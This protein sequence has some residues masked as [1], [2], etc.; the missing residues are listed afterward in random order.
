MSRSLVQLAVAVATWAVAAP[1]SAQ[2]NNPL[3]LSKSQVIDEFAR[4]AGIGADAATL[5]L[6]NT[7]AKLEKAQNY[8]AA[9][10]IVSQLAD[11]RDDAAASTAIDWVLG[12]VKDKV[13]TGPAAAALTAVTLYKSSLEGLRDWV[14]YPRWN[15][16]MYQE[17]KRAR[18]EGRTRA[19][20]GPET[21]ETAYNMATG[22]G[23]AY[24][25][26]KRG[27]YDD[28]IRAKGLTKDHIGPRVDK[29]LWAQIDAYLEARMELRFQRDYLRE[30]RDEIVQAYWREARTEL[31]TPTA[32]VG[33]TRPGA[34]ASAADEAVLARYKAAEE[35]RMQEWLAY[36]KRVGNMETAY[37][38]DWPVLRIEGGDLLVATVVW[39]KYDSK[40]KWSEI[41]IFGSAQNPMRISLSTLR[42]KY[43][44]TP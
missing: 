1:A 40:A 4:G 10:Q 6:G 38:W 21:I 3:A 37:K 41:S 2:G 24:E 14:V 30:H 7:P 32:V 26:L 11:A 29:S 39:K 27:I 17:Y 36:D 23:S 22:A 34:Q 18:T 16:Q 20:D 44:P 19:G 5:S 25:S 28:L 33:A 15:E 8:L 31:V 35:A 9:V 43:P 42:A 12:K 13:V